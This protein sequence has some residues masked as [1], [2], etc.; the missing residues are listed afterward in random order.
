[1]YLYD[2]GSGRFKHCWKRPFAGFEPTD[3]DQ[4]INKQVGK[5]SSKIRQDDAQVL[6]DDGI[7][8]KDQNDRHP[9]IIYNVFEG[10]PY[11]AVPTEYGKSYHGYPWQ[12]RMPKVVLGRLRSRAEEQGF[13]S[14]F[15][16]WVEK[17][18]KR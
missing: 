12:G 4:P 3:E 15:N 6:L 9:G 18:G 1:M 2:R 10:I 7:P 8:V 16:S 5:C 13:L 17:Y 14:Q 11:E